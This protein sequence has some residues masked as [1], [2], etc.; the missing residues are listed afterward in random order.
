MIVGAAVFDPV[1]GVAAPG[2]VWRLTVG[3]L[4]ETASSLV[5]GGAG[6]GGAVA[7]GAGAGDAGGGRRRAR[8]EP[9]GLLELLRSRRT[10][11]CGAALVGGRTRGGRGEGRRARRDT[12]DA[13]EAF[14]VVQ[15]VPHQRVVAQL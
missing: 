10:S 13:D 2:D 12:I 11:G 1:T 5:A 8:S 7:G 6:A 4:D 14:R 9:T 3:G 15:Q